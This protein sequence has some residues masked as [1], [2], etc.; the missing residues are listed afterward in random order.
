MELFC[1]RVQKSP[2]CPPQ[3]WR[4]VCR[5]SAAGHRSHCS[6]C[7]WWWGMCQLWQSSQDQCSLKEGKF[8]ICR[9]GVEDMN[10]KKPL[11]SSYKVKNNFAFCYFFSHAIIS[12]AC[13]C[14]WWDPLLHCTPTPQKFSPSLFLTLGTAS[15]AQH[16][17]MQ[18]F[19]TV[20]LLDST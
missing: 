20:I 5:V 18:T 17:R 7:H 4:S 10:L 1:R 9:C 14:I 15:S 11:C 19:K 6:L 13:V 3:Q 12:L 16:C 2:Q 8:H